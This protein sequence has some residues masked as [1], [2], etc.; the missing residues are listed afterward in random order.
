MSGP[1]AFGLN[2]RKQFCHL[3]ALAGLGMTDYSPM[4]VRV[5]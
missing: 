3:L 2:T 5:R 4:C 1:V